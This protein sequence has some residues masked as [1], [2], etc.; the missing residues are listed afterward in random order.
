[1]KHLTFVMS[2]A[3]VLSLAFTNPVEKAVA[4]KVDVAGSAVKWTAYKVTGK[5]FGKITLK[6]GSLEMS[7]TKL[8]KASFEVDMTTL[9]VEDITGEYADK[10]KGHLLSD[11]FF[12]VEKHKTAKFVSTKIVPNGKPNGFS[13][14]GDLT[15]KGITKPITFD[16]V[17]KNTSGKVT[18]TAAI[19]V[20]RTNYDI[21]YRSGRFFQ[22][23][24]DKAIYDEFDLEVSLVANK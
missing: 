7:K 11:D 14:T 21:K 5:H 24:G 6:T 3:A 18:G 1:M 4:Y 15:I 22:D 17:V 20:D 9:T 2:L 19:K 23:L 16:A 10:L 8:G 12:S 13:V